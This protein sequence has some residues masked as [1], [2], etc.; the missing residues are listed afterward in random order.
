MTRSPRY[1]SEP[2]C[3]GASP[4]HGQGLFTKRHYEWSEFLY[5]TQDYQLLPFP[6]R[7]SVEITP[8]CHLIDDVGLRWVN[9]SCKANAVFKFVNNVAL[10]VAKCDIP[11]DTEITC[12]YTVSES[13]IPLPF[14]CN[15]SH[16]NGRII[17]GHFLHLPCGDHL[18]LPC[19]D[20]AAQMPASILSAPAG[21]RDFI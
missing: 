10:L 18:G 4:I 20:S 11:P 19:P 8:M 7:G 12:D 2:L 13:L 9:H 5:A 16:C 6:I 1:E 14:K 17:A 15:C 21:M 3:M